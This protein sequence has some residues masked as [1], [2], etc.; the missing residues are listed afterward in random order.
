MLRITKFN[1]KV[2]GGFMKISFSIIALCLFLMLTSGTCNRNSSEPTEVKFV[3]GAPKTYQ[4]SSSQKIELTDT[5]TGYKFSFPHGGTGSLSIR[6]ITGSPDPTEKPLKKFSLSYTGNDTMYITIP[7]KKGDYDFLCVYGEVTGASL[8]N[9][10]KGKK[11]WHSISNYIES[12]TEITFIIP[13]N[14]YLTTK[15]SNDQPQTIPQQDFAFINIAA[16]S[17]R[18]QVIDLVR[19]TIRQDVDY[20]ATFLA[21]DVRT[22]Y[23]NR[24]NLLRFTW[25]YAAD[26]EGSYFAF[27]NGWL[28]YY[29]DFGFTYQPGMSTPV[30]HHEAGHLINYLLYGVTN[31]QALWARFGDIAHVAFLLMNRGRE[32]GLQEDIAYINENY[33]SDNNSIGAD[34][35]ANEMTMWTRIT[36]DPKTLPYIAHPSFIDFPSLE[37]MAAAV[38]HQ[39][40]ACNSQMYTFDCVNGPNVAYKRSLRITAPV[41]GVSIPDVYCNILLKCPQTINDV[42]KYSTD[43]LSGLSS[44]MIPKF[45]VRLEAIGWSYNGKAR[46]TDNNNNPIAGAEVL[47]VM[48]TGTS[49]RDYST[50]YSYKS[51][52]NGNCVI[53]RIYPGGCILRVFY[54]NYKDS[55]DFPSNISYTKSTNVTIEYGT[56]KIVPPVETNAMTSITQSTAIGGGNVNSDG[57]FP[58]TAKGICWSTTAN[59]TISNSHTTNGSGIGTF[60]SNLT[61]LT[62]NTPYFVRAYATNS[63]GTKYGNQVSFTTSAVS[64]SLFTNTEWRLTLTGDQSESIVFQEN[65]YSIYM[66]VGTDYHFLALSHGSYSSSGNTATMTPSSSTKNE[67]AT[68]DGDKLTYGKSTYIRVK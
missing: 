20:I 4:I 28:G 48:Q 67:I 2:F 21:T 51:D 47:P 27:R 17:S 25:T 49:S 56:L 12:N 38:V 58:V 53:P 68:I 30:I 16:N 37:G 1:K 59:P 43:F 64:G 6:E 18:A 54:N 3:Y 8:S 15:K 26:N 23:M 62:P 24:Y 39:L 33:I 19:Q 65:T 63:K 40:T 42:M 5:V 34:L 36:N 10:P 35:T 57:G 7:H 13:P 32:Q 66:G 31:Y 61:G 50:I 44:D 41:L 9:I 52:A 11:L 29:G 45:M 22:T 55:A 46:I 14:S 60:V